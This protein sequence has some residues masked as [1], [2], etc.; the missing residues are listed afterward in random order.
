MKI[1]LPTKEECYNLL[2]EYHVPRNVVAHSENV[3]K[4]SIFLAK[5]LKDKGQDVN[6]ELVERAALLHDLV[7]ICDFKSFEKDHFKDFGFEITDD[8]YEEMKKVR[9]K[10]IDQHH[11]E[12]CFDILKEQYPELALVIKK[13]RY[14]YIMS[15][16]DKPKTWEEKIVYYADKRVKHDEIVSLK[17]RLDDGEKRNHHMAEKDSERR[18]KLRNLNFELEKEIFNI[19]E[20]NPEALNNL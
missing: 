9:E 15:K 5:K 14:I 4:V 13:H 19:I 7:R 6:I 8:E 2:K 11:A 20:I 18:A 12:A 1:E 17:D 3:A 16:N 10:F